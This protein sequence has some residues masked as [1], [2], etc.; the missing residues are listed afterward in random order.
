MFDGKLKA[1]TILIEE[2]QQRI[3]EISN[4]NQDSLNRIINE[5]NRLLAELEQK[6]R[7]LT[8]FSTASEQ[9]SRE[10]GKLKDDL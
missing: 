5:N 3:N 6:D 2:L 8:T 9:T 7:K 1:K 10:M 4:S